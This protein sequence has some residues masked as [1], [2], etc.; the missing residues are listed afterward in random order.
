MNSPKNTVEEIPHWLNLIEA[1]DKK[2]IW[3]WEYT[4][5]ND[6]SVLWLANCIW[7]GLVSETEKIGLAT[8]ISS[9]WWEQYNSNDLINK[10]A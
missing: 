5:W 10:W 6:I 9:F 2:N 7:I 8:H 3:E 1:K 4:L